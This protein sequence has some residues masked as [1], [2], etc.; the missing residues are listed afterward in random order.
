MKKVVRWMIQKMDEIFLKINKFLI[1]SMM[2][3]MFIIVF[4]NVVTRYLFG[5]SL[6]WIEE[7]SRILMIAI[8]FIGAGLALREGRH[9]AIEFVIDLIKNEKL[10][11]TVRAING[12]IILTFMG[13]LSYLGFMYSRETMGQESTVLRWDM[14]L[15][16]LLIPIGS[17]TFMMH[18]ILMFKDFINPK[19]IEDDE[20]IDIQKHRSEGLI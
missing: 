3:S 14:G 7:V 2:G 17:I 15:V 11:K 9:V 6:V 20:K 10:N 18:L 13:F 1:G 19:L 12:L 16:Y 8:C 4:A 5:I